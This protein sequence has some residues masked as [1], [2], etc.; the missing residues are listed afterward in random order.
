MLERLG[1]PRTL[2]GLWRDDMPWPLSSW[3]A[4]SGVGPETPAE[5]EQHVGVLP[6]LDLG[7]VSHNAIG[8]LTDGHVLLRPDTP[9]ARVRPHHVNSPLLL[10]RVVSASA[11]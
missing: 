4:V 7:L 8:P 1:L 2:G 3:I 10:R 5:D 9:A 11:A 6:L